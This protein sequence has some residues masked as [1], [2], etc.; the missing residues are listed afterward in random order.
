MHIS[1]YDENFT[2]T[3]LHSFKM[4]LLLNTCFIEF[5]EESVCIIKYYSRFFYT[6]INI[7]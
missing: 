6:I 4:L 1:N 5:R 2:D 7:E 3:G